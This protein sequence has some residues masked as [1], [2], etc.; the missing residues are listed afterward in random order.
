MGTGS[1]KKEQDKETNTLEELQKLQSW[2]TSFGVQ[3]Y[4]GMDK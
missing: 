3:G 2:E 1:D 4:V